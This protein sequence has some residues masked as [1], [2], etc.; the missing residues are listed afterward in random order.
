MAS[1]A[2]RFASHSSKWFRNDSLHR[3]LAK[4][5]R[6]EPRSI[7]KVVLDYDAEENLAGIDIDHA[8]RKLDL[9]ELVTSQ[10]PLAAKA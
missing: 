8:S 3:P 7:E 4:T 10:L 6:R 5:E 2:S 1:N 9:R